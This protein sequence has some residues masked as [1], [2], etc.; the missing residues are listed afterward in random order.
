MLVLDL[1]NCGPL[2]FLRIIYLFKMILNIVLLIIPIA[3][4]VFISID[5][6]KV[7]ISGDDKTQK[8]VTKSIMNRLIFAV[9]IFFAP[10][11]VK[12]VNGL[13][14]ESGVD[15]VTCYND[16][17]KEIIEQLAL[18]EQLKEEAEVAAKKV[19]ENNNTEKQE[20]E[21]EVREQSDSDGV[22]G[23]DGMVYYENGIFYK[24]SSSY[25]NGKSETKGSAAYG[26]NKYFY[27]KL[28][29]MVADAKKAGYT[30]SYSTTA[31]GAWRSYEKQQYFYNCY[32]T[33]SCNNGNPASYPGTSNHGWGI[34]SDLKY[35]S[36]AARNWAHNNAKNYGLKFSVCKSYPNNCSEPWHISPAVTKTD[37]SVVNK[38]K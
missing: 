8:T 3:L 33:K 28:T 38:C 27:E 36:S 2:D 6:A 7:V 21:E 31:S 23:C 24:P 20:E 29:A 5:L 17:S 14:G 37:D 9:L 19:V 16:V 18:E 35:G 34:A 15:F 26:Y 11:I 13:I 4:I 30:I 1:S 32:T 10:T 22:S 25:V 12:F